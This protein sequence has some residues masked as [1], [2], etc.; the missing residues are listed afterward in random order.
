[1]QMT[2]PNKPH[3]IIAEI[4]IDAAQLADYFKSQ[5]YEYHYDHTDCIYYGDGENKC[6]STCSQYR[7]GWNDAM[8]F[9]F[10]DGHGYNPWRRRGA[11]PEPTME[12]FMYGQDMGSP[13]DGSL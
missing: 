2:D 4:K 13:E 8:E 3:W 10:K 7:D 5:K 6:P 9:I 11:E 1:M 12:E